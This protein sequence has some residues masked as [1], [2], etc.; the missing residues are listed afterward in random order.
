MEVRINEKYRVTVIIPVFKVGSFIEK[1]ARSLFEQT[2]G[3]IEY[4]FVDDCSPDKSVE[5]L[6]NALQDYPHLKDDVRIIRHQTNKGLPSARNTGL[7]HAHGTY[8]FHCDGDDWVEPTMIADMVQV[9]EE[10]NVDIVYA[11]FFLTFHQNERYMKQP[12]YRDVNSCIQGMLN[13]AM[14]YNVWNKLVRHRLY[15][16]YDVRFPD[17][18]GMGEDMTMVKLFCHANSIA[19]IPKAY[20]HYMQTN[21][22]AFTKQMS[23]KQLDDVRAN[24]DDLI[25][26]IENVLGKSLY[27]DH[28]NYL[29][30][31]VKL[32]FLIGTDSKMYDLWRVWY[33]EANEYIRKNPAFSSRIRFLQYAALKKK[34]WIVKMYNVLIL[35]CV[36]GFIY[37]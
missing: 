11:D 33:P 19:H 21:T 29:K 34:D 27:M 16:E 7:V 1:C 24:A 37:R 9:M 4:V 25:S 30:L 12:E 20:Y 10:K 3:Q 26:Y 23:Q 36:Y 5:I 2:L 13:G 8:I 14:K 28:I 15:L 18:K 22:Y 6:E 31:N 17:G 35:R 32:P